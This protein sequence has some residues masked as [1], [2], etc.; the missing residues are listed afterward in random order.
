MVTGVLRVE[1]LTEGIHSGASG[2]VP[3]SFRIARQ[4]L[5]R[6][7]DER[8]GEILVDD[9]RAE[10]P[11]V[12]LAE[13]RAVAQ[14]LDADVYTSYPFVPGM[15]P[16]HD[17]P[18]ELLLNNTWRPA[19]AITGAGGLPAVADAGNVL[20]PVTTLKLSLRLPPTTDAS[21]AVQT[22][23]RLFETNPPYGA[24][25]TFTPL[26]S[27]TG[28][29]APP[30][31]PWLERAVHEA[32]VAYFGKPAM[33]EGAGV[34]IPFARMLGERFPHAQFLITGVLGPGSNAHGANEFLHV[35]TAVR[36]TASVAQILAAH[37]EAAG[38]GNRS[39]HRDVTSV[40][41]G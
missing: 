40:R 32:S 22:V 34:G 31:S 14:S 35:P 12:R 2:I 19:L 36:L 17:E 24:R 41:R 8:T 20:R 23:R 11:A 27:A 5:S 16:A 37:G 29:N 33:L 28:W 38:G 26:T 39:T 10:I 7:E 15:R 3:S 13:A 30:L 21:R 4:L 6:L 1:V 9:L 25:V 18:L